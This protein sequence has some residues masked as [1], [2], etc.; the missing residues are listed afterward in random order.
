MIKIGFIVG[1]DDQF[2]KDNVIKKSTPKKY[3][4]FGFELHIDVAI[5][6]HIK[7]NYPDIHVD[8]ILPKDIT[9]E[10]LKKNHVNFHIGY[11]CLN[12]IN[13]DPFVKKFSTDEGL[14][15]IYDIFKD[16]SCKIF[17]P[18]DHNNFTW[19]KKLYMTKYKRNNLP[20]PDSIFF[21]PN[22]NIK[23]LLN[24]IKTYGW[25]KFIMKPIGATTAF[26]FRK[27]T[28]NDCLKDTSL[29]SDYLKENIN[30][31]EFIVQLFI[32]GFDKFGEIKM[33]WING[34]FSYAVNI[35]RK[36]LSGQKEVVKFVKD[37][38]VLEEYKQIGQK[39]VDLFPPIIVNKKKVKP[40]LVRTDFTCCLD[41][42]H[43]K[44]RYYLNEVEN[45]C[46]HTYSDKPGITYPYMQVISDTFVKKAYELIGLG[47]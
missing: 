31:K 26:G 41:N 8:I 9:K 18:Y 2:Y 20:I 47:F 25:T 17:P 34:E 43:K 16:K 6:M 3:L 14:K 30:Y 42:D 45:Q 4:A 46:A 35:K 13:N 7:M 10:R 44:Q 22:G 11:D 40:V 24:Q 28:L 29:I 12:A 15:E 38:K 36:D 33:M 32:K 27:F 1:K 37:K 21:K 39:A 5:A 19:N 23:R